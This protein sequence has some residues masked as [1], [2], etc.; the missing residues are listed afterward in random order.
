MKKE[1]K[2]L[3][4]VASE[5]QIAQWQK[6]YGEVRRIQVEDKACYLRNVDRKVLGLATTNSGGDTIKFNEILLRNC[7]LDGDMEI[8]NEDSY[9]LGASG[10]LGELVQVKQATIKKL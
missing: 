6:K 1:E 10:T 3:G 8:Q 5:A 4:F 9:F 7:W 2:E